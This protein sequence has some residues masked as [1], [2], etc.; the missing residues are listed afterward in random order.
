[1]NHIIYIVTRG[2]IAA[3][4]VSVLWGNAKAND[5]QDILNALEVD[6]KVSAEIKAELNL[7]ASIDLVAKKRGI[8]AFGHD[9]STHCAMMVSAQMGA[10]LSAAFVRRMMSGEKK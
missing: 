3:S 2:L 8:Q 6:A 5:D 10:P 7:C 4:L 9:L 1:M